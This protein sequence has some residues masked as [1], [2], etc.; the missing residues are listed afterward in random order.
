VVKPVKKREV[1]HYLM[2]G[3]RIGTRRAYRCVPLRRSVVLLPQLQGSLDRYLLSL[4]SEVLE[5]ER[6]NRRV[7][8]LCDG[9]AS[10]RMSAG[11]MTATRLLWI[12]ARC[13]TPRD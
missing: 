12:P 1:V 8:D 13:T 2:S 6:E 4:R 11:I 9:E 10:L 3:Y 7:A 5:R